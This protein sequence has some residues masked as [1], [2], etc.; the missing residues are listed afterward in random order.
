MC[1]ISLRHHSILFY[2]HF[3]IFILNF[4]FYFLLY[5]QYSPQ[6][7]HESDCDT[8]VLKIRIDFFDKTIFYKFTF[9]NL[10]LCL[11]KAFSLCS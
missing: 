6:P 3:F 1:L 7:F 9:I 4:K 5:S 8:P 10:G 2:F 11:Y